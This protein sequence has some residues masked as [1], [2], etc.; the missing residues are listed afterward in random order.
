MS[1]ELLPFS[2]FALE[3]CAPRTLA[4]GPGQALTASASAAGVLSLRASEPTPS[5][6]EQACIV[7]CAHPEPLTITF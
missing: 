4:P 7:P 6:C 1:I 3:S 5:G 2:A